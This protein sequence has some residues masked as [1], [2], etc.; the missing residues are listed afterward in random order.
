MYPAIAIIVF[1]VALFVIARN[2]PEVQSAIK[3]EARPEYSIGNFEI[4]LM[5]L[6]GAFLYSAL[7][8]I[9]VPISLLGFV[10]ILVMKKAI[11]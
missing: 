8:P 4:I 7:W 10:G 9:T 11:K 1:L 2:H 6:V 3:G 5:A